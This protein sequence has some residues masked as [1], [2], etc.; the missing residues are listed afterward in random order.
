M[1]DLW[2]TIGRALTNETVLNAL[3][4]ALPPQDYLIDVYFRGFRFSPADYD[5]ARDAIR[6]GLSAAG[7]V[8]YPVSLMALGELLYTSSTIDEHKTLRK[9]QHLMQSEN[10]GNSRDPLFYTALGASMVDPAVRQLFASG[11]FQDVMFDALNPADRALLTKIASASQFH[12]LSGE[13][14]DSKWT[15]DCDLRL[16]FYG[17]HCH[18]AT[19]QAIE[20]FLARRGRYGKGGG[21]HAKA[22]ASAS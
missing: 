9:A 15:P 7:I 13:F 5:R 14:E 20:K 19:S 8:P 10:I 12:H 21:Q 11:R 17:D 16:V 6:S 22:S 18:H 3:L 1:I 4:T 2:M